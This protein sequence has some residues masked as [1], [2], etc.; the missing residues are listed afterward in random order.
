MDHADPDQV[1]SKA[2]PG[3]ASATFSAVADHAAGRLYLWLDPGMDPEEIVPLYRLTE[4][5]ADPIES[6]Q[7]FQDGEAVAVYTG[8][9]RARLGAIETPGPASMSWRPVFSPGSGPSG[10][11]RSK[12]SSRR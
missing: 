1:V 3:G 8:E 7:S 9:N 6:W 2:M 5:D 4:K 11:P 12:S 10:S